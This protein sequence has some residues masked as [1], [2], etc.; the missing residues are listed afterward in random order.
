MIQRIQSVWLLLA[1]VTGLSGIKLPFYSGT[2]PKG[3]PS[4]TLEATDDMA[5][6]IPTIAVGVLSLVCIFL[7]RNRT[8][9]FRL[10][11]LAIILQVAVLA[12]YWKDSQAYIGGTF[13]LTAIMQVLA[14]V[15]LVLAAM[16]IKKDDK[17]I[18]DSNRLR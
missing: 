9:Q 8:T 1:S 14:I 17:I 2:D 10:T 7:F 5:L 4:S 12:L 6:L 15:F 18:R 13:A 11:A 16:G 3:I